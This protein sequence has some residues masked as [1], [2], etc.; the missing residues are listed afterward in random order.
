M[1][2]Y[3]GDNLKKVIS[4]LTTIYNEPIDWVISC[5]DSVYEQCESIYDIQLIVIIDN[6]SIPRDYFIRLQE[7]CDKLQSDRFTVDVYF[8]QS[9]IGLAKSL[10]KAF[11]YAKGDFI[12]RIDT[13]DICL[14]SRFKNQ[15][16]YLINNPDVSIV[17]G[18][19]IRMDA[20]GN[21]IG[22]ARNSIDSFEI[23]KKIKYK[24]VCYHPTWMMKREIF[25][26][27][28]GYRPYPNSQDFDFLLRAFESNALITNID[29][30]VVRYRIRSD[31]LSFLHSLRQRLCQEHILL[32]S[33][34][35]LKNDGVDN[36]SVESMNYYIS[37][38]NF[39]RML[40]STS[41]KL[42]Y[43][44]TKKL[45]SKNPLLIALAAVSILTSM[46]I[47]PAQ[48]RHVARLISYFLSKKF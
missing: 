37:H 28:D 48:F 20:N 3:N 7:Y 5:V 13:D 23:R 16:K 30:Y 8:N 47:S 15:F 33:N 26:K 38:N 18:H 6:P 36:F 45:K 2:H 14:P 34:I 43:F 32:M 40:H 4:V 46:M 11:E 42:F 1:L 17:G 44:S 27:L 31:S 35:R 24:S 22:L 9:N 25:I 21:N 41:Q 12:A 10:N 29:E 19:M 39:Y